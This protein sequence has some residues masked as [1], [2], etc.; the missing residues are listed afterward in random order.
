MQS[1]MLKGA[2]ERI[3]PSAL[4]LGMHYFPGALPQAANEYRAFG[5]NHRQADSFPCPLSRATFL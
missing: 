2:P 1:I 4:H 3:A 5:A